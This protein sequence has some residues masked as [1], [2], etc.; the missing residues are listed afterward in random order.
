MECT[1]WPM[2]NLDT[3]IVIFHAIGS[4]TPRER[5]LIEQ[6][7]CVISDIVFWELAMLAGAGRIETNIQG[8]AF[9]SILVSLRAIPINLEIASMSTRLDFSSDPADEIIAATSVVERIPLLTRDRR[10]L[11]SRMVPF[12]K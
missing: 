8:A 11:K 12:A 3:H 5:D 10:I 9:Q 1:V 4:T 2:L 7:R 6:S